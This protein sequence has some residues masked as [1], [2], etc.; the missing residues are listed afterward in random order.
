MGR[1]L[2]AFDND[3]D[4]ERPDLNKCP[5]CGC[6]FAQDTCPVCGKPCPEEMRAGNRKPV[7]PKR[8]KRRHTSDRVIFVNWYHSW[9]FILLMLVISPLIGIV[10][11]ITSPHNKTLKITVVTV[12]ALYAVLSTFGIGNLI[13]YFYN[14]WNS[15][16]DTF[17][18]REEYIA[19]CETVDPETFYRSAA[20]YTD[21]YV[22]ISLRI[23]EKITDYDGYYTDAKYTTY[24]ICQDPDG[25]EFQ[26]LIRDCLQEEQNFLA[27]D[28]I[29]VY[30]E[31]AGACTVYDAAYEP[32]TAPCLY[33][34]YAVLLE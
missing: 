15:P 22:S 31:G 2:G 19:A 32:F 7:R 18:D 9:W 10:L 24:Y 28:V 14:L 20:A 17:L 8:K 4:L 13:G 12:G 21:K 11:L 23:T 26:I 29:T 30:G 16:V 3:N 5:D 6:F 1:M 25:G 33:V 34:V 27:G